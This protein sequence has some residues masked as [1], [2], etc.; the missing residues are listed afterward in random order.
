MAVSELVKMESVVRLSTS[1]ILDAF[2]IIPNTFKNTPQ[3][4]S[5]SLSKSLGL[6]SSQVC[7]KIE[8][9]NSIG[10]FKGRGVSFFMDQ[11]K[12]KYDQYYTASAGNFGQAVAYCSDLYNVQSTIYVAENA[13]KR[14][15]DKM[16]NL[17]ANIIKYGNDFDAAKSFGKAQCQNNN[18]PFIEDGKFS[19]ITEGAA[20]IA[21]EI[22]NEFENNIGM[23]LVPVGNGALISGI[24]CWMKHYDPS[25]KVI[26]VCSELAQSMYHSYF[27]K[28]CV[29]V[30]E[31]KMLALTIAD[32]ID[33]RLPV[34]EAVQW[35]CEYV[36][37]MVLVS[38]DEIIE[39]MKMIFEAERLIVE[40]SGAVGIA[41]VSKLLKND[42]DT[43]GYLKDCIDK[44]KLICAVLTGSNMTDTDIKKFIFL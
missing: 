29:A 11:N 26:G 7:L 34:N 37:D 22:T 28:K 44:E 35:M 9:N 17:G 30:E 20:T 10:C 19:E 23:V 1:R 6:P 33:V 3:Y 15:I 32:G 31:N 42:N 43:K 36:D 13:N 18:L 8:T 41:A 2:K 16:K 40:P 24:G 4:V 5:S 21:L 14:K 12:D 25:I 39:S 27:Q 38:D